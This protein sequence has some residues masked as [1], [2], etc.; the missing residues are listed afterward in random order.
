[1]PPLFV[2]SPNAAALQSES[3]MR[4]VAMTVFERVSHSLGTTENSQSD[5]HQTL[6]F[7]VRQAA[8]ECTNQIRHSVIMIEKGQ[9][10]YTANGAMYF[11]VGQD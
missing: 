3:A 9:H 10:C 6:L 5:S 2:L 8:L 11:W 7:T 4:C 1:M